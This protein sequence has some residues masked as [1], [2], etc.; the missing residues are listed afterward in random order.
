MTIAINIDWATML[1]TILIII[2]IL[3]IENSIIGYFRTKGVNYATKQD[4]TDITKKIESVKSILQI[5]VGNEARIQ[6]KRNEAIIQFFEDCMTL[7]NKLILNVFDGPMDGGKQLM[8][9]QT[10]IEDLFTKIL[11][12][13]YRLLIYFDDGHVIL[14]SSANLVETIKEARKIF[15]ENFWDYKKAILKEYHEAKNAAELQAAGQDSPEYFAAADETNQAAK[16]YYEK[17][18]PET[19]NVNTALIQCIKVLNEYFKEMGYE[20]S[21]AKELSH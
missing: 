16:R 20:Q 21:M 4:I 19:R 11:S 9:Y 18:D 12:D 5:T 14:S 6:K 3:P 17:M 15:K 2:I 8:E 7:H 13:Y 1:V 10:S